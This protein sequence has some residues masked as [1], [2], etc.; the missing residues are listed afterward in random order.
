MSELWTYIFKRLFQVFSPAV[1]SW[2]HMIR[3]VADPIAIA[4][5][6]DVLVPTNTLTVLAPYSAVIGLVPPAAI[7]VKKRRN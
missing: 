1:G 6:D 2:N 5:V 7:A 4:P 3:A